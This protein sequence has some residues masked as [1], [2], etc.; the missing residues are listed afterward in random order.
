LVVA[1][2][3]LTEDVVHEAADQQQQ[4]QVRDQ[5]LEPVGARVGVLEVDL[6]LVVAQLAGDSRLASGV[7]GET[8]RVP[9]PVLVGRDG[10]RALDAY[11]LDLAFLGVVEQLGVGP[12]RRLALL[13]RRPG[14]PEDD[15][16]TDS[17]SNVK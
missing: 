4:D 1:A 2:L 3:G 10:V 11:V 14:E 17:Q 15:D 16:Q 8:D 9:L 6:D 12:L 5:D 13:D 7:I